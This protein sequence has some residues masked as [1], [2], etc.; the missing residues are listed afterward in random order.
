[1]RKPGQS[2]QYRQRAD[3]RRGKPVIDKPSNKAPC[4]VNRIQR[5]S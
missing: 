3:A 2:S 1:V 4:P 5:P